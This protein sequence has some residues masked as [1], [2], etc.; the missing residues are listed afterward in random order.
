MQRNFSRRQR[1]GDVPRFQREPLAMVGDYLREVY[2][3]PFRADADQVRTHTVAQL[4][5][6]RRAAVLR[7]ILFTTCVLVDG[8]AI[9]VGLALR[10]ANDSIFALALIALLALVALLRCQSGQVMLATLLFVC[11]GMLLGLGF[12]LV[13]SPGID[14]AVLGGYSSFTIFMLISALLLPPA[15]AWPI[16]LAAIALTIVAV[17]VTPLAPGLIGASGSDATKTALLGELVAAEAVTALLG[18]IAARSARA[19]LDAAAAALARE[20]EVAA[21]KDR[22][23]VEIN[24]ELRTPIMTWYGNID[25][26]AQISEQVTPEKRARLLARAVEAGDVVIQMFQQFDAASVLEDK[27]PVVHVQAVLVAPLLASTLKKRAEKNISL[28]EP[29]EVTVQVAPNLCARADPELFSEVV[30]H[31]VSNAMKYSPCGTPILITGEAVF[32]RRRRVFARLANDT[33]AQPDFVRINVRDYGQ[34]IP[35]ADI[36]KLFNRF[37]RLERD[38][39]GTVRGMGVGL[40]RCRLL[41]EA[42]G[43]HIWVESQGVPGEG[44]TF[45]FTLPAAP[46]PRQPSG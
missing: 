11:G 35:R 27:P 26:L 2:T 42:M 5:Y 29:R 39:A 7:M 16:N 41:I 8:I 30:E 18:S 1:V 20:R 6:L 9:P 3:A 33:A 10:L 40:F 17:A 32:A 13:H 38:I 21:L 19:G 24:H 4:E 36:P 34:G 37:V 28:S 12:G 22:F 44:S 14:A 25:L 46:P 45:S 43:G 31:L 15:V 23:V